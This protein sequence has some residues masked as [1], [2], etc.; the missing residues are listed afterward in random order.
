MAKLSLRAS[1]LL[2]LPVAAGLFFFG[3]AQAKAASVITLSPTSSSPKIDPGSITK[4]SLEVLNQGTTSFKFIVYAAPYRVSGEDYT[5]DFTVLPN[6]PNIVSWFNFSAPD[7][8]LKPGQ[9]KT[10]NYTISVP[11]STLAGGYYAAVF[12]ETQFA[13]STH[14]ITLNERVGELFYIQVNGN[15]VQKGELLSWQSPLLQ[16]RPLTSVIRIRDDGGVHFPADIR[17]SV[18]DIL[19]HTKYQ[20]S[21]RKELLPQTVR[22]V[23]LPWPKT[24]ALG[25]FKVSGDATFL[26]QDHKLGTKWVLVMSDTVRLALLILVGLISLIIGLSFYLRRRR[27][28]RK[29]EPD[30]KGKHD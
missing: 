28:R 14:G 9:A 23:S 24:P 27:K 29:T 8:F 6:A 10:I 21:A 3:S 1:L 4:G 2:V 7:A 16:K 13:Q 26:G 20:L 12:A 11:Q 15:I 17:L 25:L 30:A 19:G 22:R 18:K 5:P